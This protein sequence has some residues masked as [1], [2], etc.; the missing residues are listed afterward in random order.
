MP[1]FSPPSKDRISGRRLNLVFPFALLKG[2]TWHRLFLIPRNV[3]LTSLPRCD[4]LYLKIPVLHPSNE[5]QQNWA[6]FVF[7]AMF[8]PSTDS[9]EWKACLSFFISL[10]QFNADVTKIL[11]WQCKEERVW[12][13]DLVRRR[14]IEVIYCTVKTQLIVRIGCSPH[15]SFGAGKC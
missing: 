10:L 13:D 8:T 15:P 3:V 12:E 14:L 5:I 9:F 11:S 6:S 1:I 2:K 7:D 4:N